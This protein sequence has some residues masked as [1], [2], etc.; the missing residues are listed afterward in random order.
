MKKK[1][2]L[3]VLIPLL[4]AIAAVGA[5]F[6][7][8]AYT[9]SKAPDASESAAKLIEGLC[10]ADLME[11]PK[12]ANGKALYETI[13]A[14]WSYEIVGEADVERRDAVQKVCIATL[15]VESLYDG[16]E[17]KAQE[18]LALEVERA[19]FSSDIYNEDLSYKD[20]VL[21]YAGMEAFLA[22]LQRCDMKNTELELKMHYQDGA[23][24]LRNADEV[25]PALIDQEL[26]LDLVA[27]EACSAAVKDPEYIRKI[28][29][30]E[31]TA[32]AGPI[33]E[34]SCF[35]STDDPAV[36]E[37]LIASRLAQQLINGQ[38]L[39]WNA[40]IKRISRTPIY[41]Y[42]DE[43]IFS[44]V[45]QEEEAR[46]V[47]TFSETFIADG[48][49]L[50]RK[51]AGDQFESFEHN[52]ATAFAQQ[53]NAVLALGGDLYH[54]DRACGIVVYEREIYR[55]DPNTCDTCYIDTEGNMLFSK[56]GQFTDISQAEEFVKENDI[57][58]S[59]CFGPVLIEDGVDVTP[60]QYQW[61]EI[62]DTYARSALGM[63]GEHHYLSV[64]IN[65]QQPHYFYLATLQQ[66][67]DA[68]MEKG[69]KIAYALDGGQTAS[70]VFNGNLIN[71]VQFGNERTTSDI[72][73]FATAVPN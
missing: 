33:P 72:I 63:L 68:M 5:Y 58:F 14:S 8:E 9:M 60:D 20:S 6:G 44:I 29:K 25:I 49:Q 12:T 53:T 30:I 47:G 67:T 52:Y 54:H 10:Q 55:F 73:Y 23:W 62:H 21:K 59:I 32:K 27:E 40:D 38:E 31:E 2:L 39:A 71:P 45:W 22:G 26:D 69:C 24:V 35:G 43:T 56:R 1:V 65:C 41:Y 19:K 36:I 46:A 48:S 4:L 61:G 11:E 18:V 66:A 57:L 17:E 34:Q 50:R 37:A 28:Y 42:L 15:D 3:V 51:I 16:L 64:N 13:K 70:T 7:F